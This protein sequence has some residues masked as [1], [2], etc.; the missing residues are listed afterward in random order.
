MDAAQIL[1]AYEELVSLSGRM[2]AAA[3]DGKWSEVSTLETARAEIVRGLNADMSAT[4]VPAE[5]QEKVAQLIAS[6]LSAGAET[7]SQV[8]AWKRELQEILGSLRTESKLSQAYR[9]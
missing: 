8:E 7:L 4:G 9:R 5:A 2:L 3:R 1:A 6:V